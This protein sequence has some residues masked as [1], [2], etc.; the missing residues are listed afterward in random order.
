MYL[1][2]C[3]SVFAGVFV[4]EET[5]IPLL[6]LSLSLSQVRHLRALQGVGGG[7]LRC[8]AARQRKRNTPPLGRHK[9]QDRLGQVSPVMFCVRLAV[10]VAEGESE[11]GT[12]WKYCGSTSESLGV[13]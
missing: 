8:S 12:G 5:L 11:P 4:C 9:Q 6:S 10:A 2:L 13:T 3:L 1:T 7:G